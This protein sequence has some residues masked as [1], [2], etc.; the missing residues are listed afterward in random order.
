MDLK[1]SD[2]TK[3]AIKILSGTE[4]LMLENFSKYAVL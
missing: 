2:S 4:N 1:N 3:I